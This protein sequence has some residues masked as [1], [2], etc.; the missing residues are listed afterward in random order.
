MS[1]TVFY[2]G[3]T[4]RGVVL[5]FSADGAFGNFVSAGLLVL[6]PF[7]ALFLL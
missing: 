7:L 3:A 5:G 2:F 1:L 4:S 6:A